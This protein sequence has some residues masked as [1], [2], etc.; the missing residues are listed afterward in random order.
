M[1]SLRTA[2]RL[3]DYSQLRVG[4]YTMFVDLNDPRMLHIPNEVAEGYPDTSILK[5]FLT[6]GD[7]FVDVGANHGSFSIVASQAVG[8]KGFVVAIEPQKRLA[9]LI[10]KSLA[11]NAPCRYQVHRVAC[12]D[13]TD[14]VD[15]YV[16]IGSSGGAGVFR[17]FSALPRH[18]KFSVSMR[19]FDDAVDWNNFPGQVFV[20]VDVEGS[21]MNFLRGAGEMIRA[22]KPRMMLE[23]NPASRAASG[24]KRNAM[25]AY[26][27]ELGYAH[28]F[29]V[30]PFSGPWVLR[31]LL[32]DDGRR[33][34]RNVIVTARDAF[35]R[36]L[37]LGFLQ[38]GWDLL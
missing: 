5:R 36:M 22:R 35:L 4:P 6:P 26:L 13:R 30:R 23:I 15:F 21:E 31:E 8:P 33:D 11:A 18:R 24:E 3:K 7:T 17:E 37:P 20:K 2:L 1:I 29:E 34:V 32:N 9:A 19:R 25:V 28:F 14:E 38:A 12:G 16:P 27:Q 10:E